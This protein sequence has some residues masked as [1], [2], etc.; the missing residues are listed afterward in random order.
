MYIYKCACI[1]ACVC[2]CVFI[3][4]FIATPTPFLSL[5]HLFFRSFVPTLFLHS[6]L[7]HQMLAGM[8]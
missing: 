4:S 8:K 5:V 2:V 1:R 7:L 3:R 6:F